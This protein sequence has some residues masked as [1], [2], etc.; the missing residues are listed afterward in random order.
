MKVLLATAFLLLAAVPAHSTVTKISWTGSIDRGGDPATDVHGSYLYDN[1]K[2]VFDSGEGRMLHEGSINSV[3]LF[4]GN[5]EY[6]SRN[7]PWFS[8]VDPIPSFSE[9]N[10]TDN[11]AQ[12]NSFS[13][14]RDGWYISFY[15]PDGTGGWDLREVGGK[16]VSF[17]SEGWEVPPSLP[18]GDAE[19]VPEPSSF[20][21][22]ASGLA[23]AALFRRR[24]G[25]PSH[26]R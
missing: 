12:G 25:R 21:L 11:G 16:V 23:A 14:A 10:L 3:S 6:T 8:T 15:D 20:L 13:W 7:F 18:G 19:P 4:I 1:S 24:R 9:L 5:D 2:P 26:P 22:M 17:W